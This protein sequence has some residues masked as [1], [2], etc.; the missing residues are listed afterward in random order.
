[1]GLGILESEVFERAVRA[2][3][4]GNLL[5]AERDYKSILKLDPKNPEVNHNLGAIAAK[6]GKFEMALSYFRTTLD[7]NAYILQYWNSYINT[8]VHL[9][10]L[11]E[12]RNALKTATKTVDDKVEL[13]EF[14]ELVLIKIESSKSLNEFLN[15]I[16]GS[17]TKEAISF[18]NRIMKKF[19][20]EAS[21]FCVMG[22]VFLRHHE[23][24]EAIKCFTKTTELNPSHWE[25][26]NNQAIAQKSLGLF[27]EAMVTLDRLIDNKNYLPEAFNNKG[28]IFNELKQYEEAIS[29]FDQAIT[30][31]PDFS[32]AYNNRGNSFRW[33]SKYEE[34]IADYDRA[35]EIDETYA[36]AQAN[37]ATTYTL[38]GNY[39][40]AIQIFN[41][42]LRLKPGAPSIYISLGIAEA[43]A[44]YY[45]R[46]IKSFQKAIKID[47]NSA[48]AHDQ[49]GNVYRKIGH[50]EAAAYHF[51]CVKNKEAVGK[52]L[53]CFYEAKNYSELYK[54]LNE[55]WLVDQINIRVAA[56]SSFCSHQLGRENPYNFCPNGLDFFSS[57]HLEQHVNDTD[58]FIENILADIDEDQLTWEPKN[59]STRFGFQSQ[60]TIFERGTALKS[61]K[62]II[63][64]EIE[65]YY[66]KFERSS[67]SLIKSWP[68]NFELKG[69]FVRL[70]ENGHQESHIHPAGWVSGVIYLKT[71]DVP[72]SDEGAI[73]LSLHGNGLSVI[74]P[75]YP[76]KVFRPKKGDIILFPS[77]VFHRTIPFKE[78]SE[79]CVIAFDLCPSYR[80]LI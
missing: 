74:D 4:D 23:Y 38:I 19:P 14:E 58:N 6:V 17:K 25:A 68:E 15:L 67:C 32:V 72:S 51:D 44:E 8:L 29:C 64:K 75:N 49:L 37:L 54:R 66:S 55:L 52:A 39:E 63:D 56:I 79:R 28:N 53:E 9:D 78:K 20:K 12:A 50:Y 77:S 13:R 40:K 30:S 5:E 42:A 60:N 26:Y 62:D 27:E 10:R 43:H 35:I 41:E 2:H 46:A 57:S 69:W 1:M 70:L 61:L 59:K 45:D 21:L 47:E 34:A 65:S 33:L 80:R 22:N 11:T 18:S 16:A 71:I 7:A 73:E 48:L 24:N 3:K 76:K 36:D 31:K